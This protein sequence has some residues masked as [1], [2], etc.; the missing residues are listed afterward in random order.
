MLFFNILGLCE[1]VCPLR[2]GLN[3]KAQNVPGAQRYEESFNKTSYYSRNSA[4]S[5]VEIGPVA[6]IKKPNC[7]GCMKLVCSSTILCG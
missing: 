1:L 5:S 3:D 2:S 7:V 6:N 4:K